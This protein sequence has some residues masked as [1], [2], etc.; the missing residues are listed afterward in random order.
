MQDAEVMSGVRVI[1]K[2]K[3]VGLCVGVA[4]TLS[5]GAAP[6]AVARPSH[7]RLQAGAGQTP[8]APRRAARSAPRQAPLRAPRRSRAAAAAEPGSVLVLKAGGQV[9]PNGALVAVKQS[10]KPEFLFTALVTVE[11]TASPVEVSVECENFLEQGKI[12]REMATD[13][14]RIVEPHPVEICEGGP[15]L[16]EAIIHNRLAFSP[17]NIATDELTIELSRTAE[18]VRA[19]E[20]QQVEAGEEVDPREPRRC[21]YVTT[22]SKGR[23]SGKITGKKPKPLEARIKGKVAQQHVPED[24]GC[25]VKKAK[26]KSSYTLTYKGQPVFP[27]FES[28]PSVSEVSPAEGPEAGGTSEQISGTGF[29]GATAVTFGSTSAASFKVNSDS[30]ITATAPKGSGTVDVTVTTPVGTSATSAADHFTYQ[31]PPTVTEVK[32]NTGLKAGGTEVTIS[33][34]NFTSG[35]TVKFGTAAASGVKM[36]SSSSLTATAPEGTGTVDVT[37]TTAGG[38]SATSSADQ[39]TYI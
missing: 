37:V 15:W 9:L 28:P 2:S 8:P 33:G 14:W 6:S 35:S 11:G 18:A 30:S 5:I 12:Q 29:T 13:T 32:P 20:R 24:T 39:F 7:P 27:A 1:G 16:E 31:P 21:A 22:I 26:W 17:P 19:E 10:V 34:T 36:N 23:F 3:S 25:G 38:T 4:L